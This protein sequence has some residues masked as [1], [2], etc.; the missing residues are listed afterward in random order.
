MLSEQQLRDQLLAIIPHPIVYL[1][2]AVLSLVIASILTLSFGRFSLHAHMVIGLATFFAAAFSAIASITTSHRMQL[3]EE[4]SSPLSRFIIIVSAAVVITGFCGI[5]ESSYS[6]VPGVAGTWSNI[7]AKTLAVLLSSIGTSVVLAGI[8]YEFSMAKL[9]PFKLKRNSFLVESCELEHSLFKVIK[10]ITVLTDENKK[11]T[12]NVIV[13]ATA[14]ILDDHI[15]RA[16]AVKPG[17]TVEFCYLR[18]VSGYSVITG[19]NT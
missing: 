10:H 8:S 14:P 15:C 18:S 13:S 17:D 3:G 5:L 7:S 9:E 16:L 19:V 11:E 4:D 1:R 12:V 6:W 2:L